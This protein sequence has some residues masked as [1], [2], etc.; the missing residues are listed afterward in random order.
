[1]EN[2]KNRVTT[3]KLICKAK[4]ANGKKWINFS[5]KRGNTWYSV[6]F[7]KG[8]MTPEVVKVAENVMRAFIGLDANS[9]FNIA[10][11]P[12]GKVLYVENYITFSGARLEGLAGAE[13]ENIQTYR[14]KRESE[15]ISFLAPDEAEIESESQDLPF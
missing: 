11:S 5:T 1:M 15:K 4:E 3:I 8:C 2:N 9:T 13:L 7:V 6:K 14:E 12:Y 10:D